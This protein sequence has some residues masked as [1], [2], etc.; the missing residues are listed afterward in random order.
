[1][2]NALPC[3]FDEAFPKRHIQFIGNLGGW[4]GLGDGMDPLSQLPFRWSPSLLKNPHQ[5]PS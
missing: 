4:T 5:Y 3:G 2:A 1:M